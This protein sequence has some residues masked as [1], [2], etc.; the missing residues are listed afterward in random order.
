MGALDDIKARLFRRRLHQLRAA[1]R[2]TPGQPSTPVHPETAEEI[3]LLFIADDADE[4]KL[5]SNWR[6]QFQRP[7][8]K[9]TALGYFSQP[10][11]TTSFDFTALSPKDLN[12]FGAPGGP[13]VDRF[14]RESTDLV[15][16]LGPPDHPV[17]DYLAALKPARLRVGPLTSAPDAPYHIQYDAPGGLKAS[18]RQ[19]LAT[20]E[21]IFAYTNAVPQPTPIL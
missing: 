13:V 14:L 6:D 21:A 16:A 17:L 9:V 8:R 20:I 2:S 3:T 1:Q 5:I 4:R 11:G 18:V 7:G 19:R 15:L 10:T 12:W